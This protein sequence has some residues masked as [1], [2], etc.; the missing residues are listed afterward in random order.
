MFQTRTVVVAYA[1]GM[2]VTLSAAY[3]PARRASRIPPV[4]ALRD[5][6]AM[7]EQSLRRRLVIGTATIG[8]GIVGMATE[9]LTDVS[10]GIWVGLLSALADEGLDVLQVPSA[11]LAAFVLAAVLV[12]VLAAVWP[13]RRAAKL[14]VLTAITTE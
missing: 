11:Q 6:G 10:W 4:A 8:V 14:D 1:V 2:A 13:A 3:L 12:G 9:F 7:P 5:D